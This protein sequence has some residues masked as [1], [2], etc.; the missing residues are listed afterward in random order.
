[1]P[2]EGS[3]FAMAIIDYLKE[4]HIM[5][6]ITTHYSEVKAHAF[7]TTGIKSA[8]MEFNVETLSPTYRLLEGIPG[9]SNALIIASKYGMPD[10]IIRNAKSY[11]SEDNQK[12]EQMIQSIKEKNDELEILKV[13]LEKST[14]N[15]ELKRKSY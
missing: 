14:S 12:V 13:E 10:D 8:S 7:N 11:I 9:E 2:M 3:A 1:D 6:I 5:S 15:L 4:K